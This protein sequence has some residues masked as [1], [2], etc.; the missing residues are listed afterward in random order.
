MSGWQVLVMTTAGIVVGYAIGQ[1]REYRFWYRMA[2]RTNTLF[3]S[4][5]CTQVPTATTQDVTWIEGDS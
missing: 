1:I 4:P 2:V 5:M 3:I